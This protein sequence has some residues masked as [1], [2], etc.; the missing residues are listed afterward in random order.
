VDKTSPLFVKLAKM[1]T[2]PMN[3]TATIRKFYTNIEYQDIL[4]SRRERNGDRP[5]SMGFAGNNRKGSET[6]TVHIMFLRYIDY[7][8]VTVD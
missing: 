1:I 4:I 6:Q 2:E 5:S 8:C 7:C 3:G